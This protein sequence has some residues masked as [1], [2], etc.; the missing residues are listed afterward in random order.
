MDFLSALE[1]CGVKVLIIEFKIYL[2]YTYLSLMLVSPLSDA[3]HL[4]YVFFR[5]CANPTFIG[6]LTFSCRNQSHQI[7]KLLI[8]F[9][10]TVSGVCG[11]GPVVEK[12][13]E[14][15]V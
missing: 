13:A 12:E 6:C 14:V 5:K 7:Q 2:G 10:I 1:A 15:K 9:F 8:T 3:Y 11:C 4:Y